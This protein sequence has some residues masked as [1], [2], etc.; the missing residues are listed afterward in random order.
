MKRRASLDAPSIVDGNAYVE[1]LLKRGQ[2][3]GPGPSVTA[4]DLQ[5]LFGSGDFPTARVR[6]YRIVESICE[7]HGVPAAAIVKK[8]VGQSRRKDQPERWFCSAVLLRLAEH[9]YTQ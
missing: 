1:E 6:L 4:A 2:Q 3:V 7:K 9:G 5:Q 8:M